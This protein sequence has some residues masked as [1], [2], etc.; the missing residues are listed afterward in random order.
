MAGVG[1]G[2]AWSSERTVAKR[3]RS[4]CVQAVGGKRTAAVE[5]PVRTWSGGVGELAAR[6][7]DVLRRGERA[8][9]VRMEVEKSLAGARRVL[10][11]LCV[12]ER[13]RPCSPAPAEPNPVPVALWGFEG[14]PSP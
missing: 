11:G 1:R 4:A 10:A 13:A 8:W 12:P 3:R 7:L 9:D 5:L 2:R 14:A 6:F